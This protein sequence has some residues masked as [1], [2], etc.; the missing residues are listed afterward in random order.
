[1]EWAALL[2]ALVCCNRTELALM[3][4]PSNPAQSRSHPIADGGYSEPRDAVLRGVRDVK[5]SGFNCHVYLLMHLFSNFFFYAGNTYF[6]LL[7]VA[8]L[9]VKFQV[10]TEFF[11]LENDMVISGM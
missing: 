8:P 9:A 5:Q 11:C 3:T 2:A 10:C 1:M 4:A 7:R 6:L